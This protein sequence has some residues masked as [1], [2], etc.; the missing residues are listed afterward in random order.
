MFFIV[1]ISFLR[2]DENIS[3]ETISDTVEILKSNGIT[4]KCDIPRKI[5]DPGKLNYNS[6]SKLDKV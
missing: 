1:N 3:R 4:L 6:E 5:D 2:A